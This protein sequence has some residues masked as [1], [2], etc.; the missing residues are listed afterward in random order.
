MAD[1]D[2]R[3]SLWDI[4]SRERIWK[5]N[6]RGQRRSC[7]ESVFFLG[8]G[9]R[10]VSSDHLIKDRFLTPA[11][12][13]ELTIWNANT[14]VPVYGLE[15]AGGTKVLAAARLHSGWRVAAMGANG[16]I[17]ILESRD[18]RIVRSTIEITQRSLTLVSFSADATMLVA[19]GYDYCSVWDVESGKERM[20]VK[21]DGPSMVFDTT[22]TS[23]GTQVLLVGNKDDVIRYFDVD[24]GKEER[25]VPWLNGFRQLSVSGDHK[26][27]ASCGH[28]KPGVMVWEVD[29]GRK[30]T[31]F[32]AP[33]I[34]SHV[35]ISPDGKVV[36]GSR[37]GSVG[38]EGIDTWPIEDTQQ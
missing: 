7:A 26:R 32:G 35:A 1:S 12:D 15:H 5:A 29:T 27:M 25:K 17:V 3:I 38:F 13:S 19:T 18:M 22:F 4:S 6:V 24:T 37:V 11:G 8:R 33:N 28:R 2:R 14:G 16:G 36:A 30:L 10:L 23:D 34:Y 31:A 9:E 21:L 20:S